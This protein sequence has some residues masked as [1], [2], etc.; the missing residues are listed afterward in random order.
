M[1]FRKGKLHNNDNAAGPKDRPDRRLENSLLYFRLFV[2]GVL[3]IPLAILHKLELLGL[4][5]AIL[6]RCII[7]TLALGTRKGDNLDV[8]LLGSHDRSFRRGG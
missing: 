5:L 3:T 4:S 2:Q 6:C 8:L 7:S 1:Q